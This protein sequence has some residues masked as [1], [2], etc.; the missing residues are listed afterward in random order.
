[1][2]R[3]PPKQ[4]IALRR[5]VGTPRECNLR[6]RQLIFGR[7][8]SP[9]CPSG[10]EL[11][12]SACPLSVAERLG[13][14][15]PTTAGEQNKRV[16]GLE[17][18]LRSSLCICAGVYFHWPRGGVTPWL[19]RLV[20]FEAESVGDRTAILGRPPALGPACQPALVPRALA[21]RL[22]RPPLPRCQSARA[23]LLPWLPEAEPCLPR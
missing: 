7:P 23:P 2:P 14:R 5:G 21:A 12:G 17:Q 4:C 8:V 18:G 13:A 9:K 11:V 20:E 22:A 1:M 3:L 19:G 10:A 15:R 6:L 16:K